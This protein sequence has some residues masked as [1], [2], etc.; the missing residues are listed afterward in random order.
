MTKLKF[1]HVVERKLY[2]ADKFS[3][4]IAICE[5]IKKFDILFNEDSIAQTF[6]SYIRFDCKGY[7]LSDTFYRFEIELL[8]FTLIL[9]G[10]KMGKVFKSNT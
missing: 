4:Q 8:V 10:L 3:R 2:H 9:N 5:F 6:S 7:A 1:F